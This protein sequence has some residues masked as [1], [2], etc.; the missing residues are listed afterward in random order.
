M[1]VL[2]SALVMSVLLLVYFIVS[3]RDGAVIGVEVFGVGALVWVLVLML[4][5]LC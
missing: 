3:V 2:V 1:S 4:E 5:F